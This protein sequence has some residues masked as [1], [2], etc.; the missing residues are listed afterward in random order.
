MK[1]KL[2]ILLISIFCIF[3]T[4]VVQAS[5]SIILTVDNEYISL[6]QY[7]KFVNGELMIPIKPVLEQIGVQVDLIAE[8]KVLK[9]YKENQHIILK[10]GTKFTKVNGKTVVLDQAPVKIN[11]NIFA[12][13]ELI[14]KAFNGKYIWNEEDRKLEIFSSNELKVHFI[15]TEDGESIFIDYGDYDILIN[16]GGKDKGLIVA[17]YLKKLDTDDIDIMVV[18]SDDDKYNGGLEDILK[19]FNVY[20]FIYSEMKSVRGI[21]NDYFSFMNDGSN[22]HFIKNKDMIFD[23]GNGVNFRTLELGDNYDNANNTVVSMLEH[24]NIK[25]VFT[26][27]IDK[28]IKNKYINEFVNTDILKTSNY[29]N[30]T[31]INDEVLNKI[32]P[33]VI[34]LSGNSNCYR[35]NEIQEITNELTE[36]IS[37]YNTKLDGSVI[38]SIDAFDYDVN[39]VKITGVSIKRIDFKNREIVLQNLS[40]ED[41]NLSGCKV[42][43]KQGKNQFYIPEGS[44]LKVGK[45]VGRQGIFKLVAGKINDIEEYSTRVIYETYRSD[46]GILYDKHGNIIAKKK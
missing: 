8:G 32:N 38:V 24:N 22:T 28:C 20:T 19:E 21:N 34:V 33:K 35:D 11:G 18:S 4:S 27:K 14:N 46:S 25:I 40:D 42:T 36:E 1:R 2:L 17:N 5:D 7:A 23:L 12:P 31:L 45:R 41:I 30:D 37:I 29:G 15:N 6:N 26:D 39:T 16:G 10:I 3:S 44:I 9:A 13:V 43:D